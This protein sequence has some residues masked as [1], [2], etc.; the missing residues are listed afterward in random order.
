MARPLTPLPAALQVEPSPTTG[1]QHIIPPLFQS[2]AQR[3]GQERAEA[4]HRT[5]DAG[6]AEYASPVSPGLPEAALPAGPAPPGR[7]GPQ[8][9]LQPGIAWCPFVALRSG[10]QALATQ[11]QTGGTQCFYPAPWPIARPAAPG[12]L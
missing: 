9:T 8:G 3:G 7:P 1:I 11:I 4:M 12:Q 6:H 2:N 5:P 10:G